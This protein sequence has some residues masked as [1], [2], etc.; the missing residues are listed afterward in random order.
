M[1]KKTIYALGYFDGVHL[2]HK[3]LLTA[4]TQLANSRDCDS[5]A[6]TFSGHPQQLLSGSAVH[7]INTDRDRR[8]ILLRD[9]NTVVELAFTE[10][11]MA[12]PWQDFIGMLISDHHSAG[13]VC[14]SDFRF[15]S[16]GEGTA[17]L[18]QEYC[19][20]ENLVCSVVEQQYLDGIRISS[21]HIRG[22]LEGGEILEANR[23]LGHPHILCGTVQPG[24]QLGRT[25]G[26]PTANLP[27]PDELLKLPHGVYACRATVDGVSYNAI[28]NIGTRPTVSG[29]DVTVE[30]H[31]PDF[32][33]DL[34]GKTVT[35]EFLDFIRPEQKF[36]SLADLQKQIAKD[37]R[38]FQSL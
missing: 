34:Y 20:K 8:E 37:V 26:F 29:Q 2:G 13:F 18:L 24:K 5:G 33:G 35:L 4:C 38:F 32:S 31:L 30:S 25:I 21:T 6:V 15:G 10:D 16:K 9:V 1:E 14:G 22:L 12:M 19:Q 28:T 23:F 36:S 3:A 7:L 11:L 27:Y 17:Q